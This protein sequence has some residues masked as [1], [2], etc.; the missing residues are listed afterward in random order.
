MRTQRDHGGGLDAA[1][2]AYGGP[3]DQWID[4][5]TGINPHP[6][7]FALVAGTPW[8]ALPDSAANQ[9]LIDAARAFWQVP[10][11]AAILPVPGASAAI[12][13]I[14]RLVPPGR[15]WIPGPTYNEHAAAFD[16]GGWATASEA[17]SATAQ[18]LVH[19][20]N[21]TG[22]LWQAS[23]L[24]A[25][26][27]IIDESFCDICPR[28]S[29]MPQATTP[30]TLI[31]K[32]FGKF[33]GLAGL[34]LGF[35]IGDPA[36]VEDLAEMLGPWPVSGVALQ[37]GA[38]ALQ[39]QAWAETIRKRLI[40]DATRLDELMSKCGAVL[41][42]GTP[43]FRLYQVDDAATWQDRLA[44]HQI[45]SRIFPYDPTWLRLGL[46]PSNGW[47]RLEAAV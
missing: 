41:H 3:R 27:R 9:R 20:N 24:A 5:S 14:P 10:D 21:P 32:S 4:L 43:L 25:P 34:R 44:R 22:R 47:D 1:A 15:V 38:Q 2:Q 12:A 35:A 18:V 33:W 37:V 8:T 6:Y 26:L 30:G 16:F 13:Q 46:P 31:L 7:P 40:A 45:W 19:P 17:A 23:D 42:G 11:Q 36:L 39:D 29:L 28:D